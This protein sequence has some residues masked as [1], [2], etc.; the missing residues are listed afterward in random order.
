MSRLPS[1]G[2]ISI[3]KDFKKEFIQ[4]PIGF[5]A[6]IKLSMTRLMPFCKKCC[7]LSKVDRLSL[8][9]DKLVKKDIEIIEW[10]HFKRKTEASL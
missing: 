6:S 3:N 2:T 1:K 8:R 4:I 5:L 10:I 9:A 7:C